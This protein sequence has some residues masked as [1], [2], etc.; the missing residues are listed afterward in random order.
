MKKYLLNQSCLQLG[1]FGATRNSNCSQ[2]N[3][4]GHMTFYGGE[5]YEHVPINPDL[6][7]RQYCIIMKLTLSDIIGEMGM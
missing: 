4:T 2:R 3:V 5:G 1:S 6:D 7:L